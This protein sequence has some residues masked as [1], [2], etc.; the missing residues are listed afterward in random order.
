MTISG[1]LVYT[2]SSA[3]GRYP[4][5]FTPRPT[6]AGAGFLGRSVMTIE[7]IVLGAGSR[8]GANGVTYR[9]INLEG[10]ELSVPAD[11]PGVSHGAVVRCRV[12]VRWARARS[13]GSFPVYEAKVVDVLQAGVL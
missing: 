8:V 10:M 6:A 7:G 2:G 4:G 5:R 9:S 13:G 11:A 12:D 3:G 1:C